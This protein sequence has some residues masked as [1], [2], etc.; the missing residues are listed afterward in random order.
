MIS[1]DRIIRSKSSAYLL[2]ILPF[3]LSRIPRKL[4]ALLYEF[5][6]TTVLEGI[7]T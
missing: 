2:V 6:D 4:N 5:R 1:V 7:L 3:R